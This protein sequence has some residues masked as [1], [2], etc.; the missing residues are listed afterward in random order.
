MEAA[1][2]RRPSKVNAES[3]GDRTDHPG[4]ARELLDPVADWGEV[5]LDAVAQVVHHLGV[6]VE[7]RA[8]LG[9]PGG[10]IAAEVVGAERQQEEQ[11][12]G[13]EADAEPAARGRRRR[14]RGRR[15]RG[16]EVEPRRR[17]GRRDRR[18]AGDRRPFRRLGG[19]GRRR[20]DRLGGPAQRHHRRS[21]CRCRRLIAR[22][23]RRPRRPRL[24][25]GQDLLLRGRR[26]GAAAGEPAGVA[27]G[28]LH[29]AARR[30]HHAV[31]DLVLG[32]AVR[33]GQPHRHLGRGAG[34]AANRVSSVLAA[35][36]GGSKRRP[37]RRAAGPV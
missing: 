14:W 3:R 32:V 1:I 31:G 34:E 27:G 25:P 23:Q 24:Q 33:A 26:R 22:D 2:L 5:A 35:A 18:G 29:V 15:R 9:N 7:G 28:A 11:Q 4:S 30:R 17:A 16:V 10:D 21:G 20:R 37:L 12:G 36:G 8:G 13:G 6:G 19:A